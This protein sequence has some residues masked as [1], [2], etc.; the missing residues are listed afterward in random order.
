MAALVIM[1]SLGDEYPRIM[2]VVAA[3]WGNSRS[4][5]T[6]P[7]TLG[8][9]TTVLSAQGYPVRAKCRDRR[10]REHGNGVPVP[11]SELVTWGCLS[12]RETHPGAGCAWKRAQPGRIDPPSPPFP[13]SSHVVTKPS[14][15]SRLSPDSPDP[16][17]PYTSAIVLLAALLRFSSSCC[18]HA[19]IRA[20]PG[21]LRAHWLPAHQPP[22]G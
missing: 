21:K 4:M 1:C 12:C 22:R 10:M 5:K 3:G 14:P 2:R 16:L 15:S 11:T 8:P 6:R 18:F 17:D 9:I 19:P 13:R 7:R 20:N